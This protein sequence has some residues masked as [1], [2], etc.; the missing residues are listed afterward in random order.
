MEIR[1]EKHDPNTML[2]YLINTRSL[3][4]HDRLTHFVS[5]TVTK[6]L[7]IKERRAK[8]DADKTRAEEEEKVEQAPKRTR[9]GTPPSLFAKAAAAKVAG[10]D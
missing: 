9:L 2:S 7:N 4:Q 6:E 10:S 3:K 5:K 1:Y 8:E